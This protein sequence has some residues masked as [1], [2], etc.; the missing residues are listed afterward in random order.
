MVFN[1]RLRQ[2]LDCILVVAG[3]MKSECAM[4][5]A[6]IVEAAVRSCG[7]KVA[8]ASCGGSPQPCWLKPKVMGAVELKKLS[9][10]A[11]LACEKLQRQVTAI[12]GP[13]DA[14][15]WQLPRQEL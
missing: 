11:W 6:T 5:H 3:D 15:L 2:S 13:S 9:Y 4:F 12:S 14:L 7:C 8:G 1:S 10:R